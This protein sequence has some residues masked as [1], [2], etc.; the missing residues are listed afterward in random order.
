M[1]PSSE[2]Q[3]ERGIHAGHGIIGNDAEASG[4]ASNWRTGGRFQISNRRTTI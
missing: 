3:D 1:E 2:E 4:R